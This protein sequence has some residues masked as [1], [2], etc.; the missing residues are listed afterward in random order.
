MAIKSKLMIAVTSLSIAL[1]STVPASSQDRPPGCA[2][3]DRID[4]SSIE[5]AQGKIKKAGYRQIS[6]LK[7]GCDNFW[8]GTAVRDGQTIHIVLTPKGEVIVEGN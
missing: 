7:K 3:G 1:L 6:S 2:P 4:A 8:H 5:A